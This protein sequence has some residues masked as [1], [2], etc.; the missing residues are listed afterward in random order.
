MKPFRL[1][2]TVLLSFL[3]LFPIL[4]SCQ[5]K[6]TLSSQISEEKSSDQQMEKIIELYNSKKYADFIKLAEIE[7]N[8]PENDNFIL[9][10]L[11]DAYGNLGN[12]DKAFYYAEKLLEKEPSNYYAL[13]ALGNY[14]F[15][16]EELDSAEFYYNKV[17]EIRP[18][19]ARAYIHLAR[20]YEKQNKNEHAVEQY[21]NAI[22]LFNANNFKEEV[23]LFSK[24]VLSLDPNNKLAKEYLR[25]Q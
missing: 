22:E 7:L 10:A 23:I 18:S 8:K 9:L 11:S 25:T 19:Y 24:Q 20:I 13:F 14:H 15:M 21:L 4:I 17:L 5:N 6:K 3:F 16:L 1:K 2:K 12:Y